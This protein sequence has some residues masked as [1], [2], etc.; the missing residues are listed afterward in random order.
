[1]KK[2]TALAVSFIFPIIC[3]SQDKRD[4]LGIRYS[5]GVNID[6]KQSKDPLDAFKNSIYAEIVNFINENTNDLPVHQFAFLIKLNNNCLVDTVL[7]SNNANN[8]IKLNLVSIKNKLNFH[9]LTKMA[10]ERQWNNCNII[11]PFMIFYESDKKM[12]FIDMKEQGEESL[13]DSYMFD[14]YGF[15]T[16]K[17]IILRHKVLAFGKII[18]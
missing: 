1:M 11:V 6:S 2:I 16:E 7:V 17:S 9:D 14:S 18:R 3:F 4:S 5:D 8:S 13:A 10:K 15:A 12:S